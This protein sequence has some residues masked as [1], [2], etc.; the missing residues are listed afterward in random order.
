MSAERAIVTD[1][2]AHKVEVFRQRKNQRNLVTKL[3]LPDDPILQQRK[4]ADKVFDTEYNVTKP[5]KDNSDWKTTDE[6]YERAKSSYDNVI[7]PFQEPPKVYKLEKV[8]PV[9]SGNHDGKYIYLTLF[10]FSIESAWIRLKQTNVLSYY[11]IS[12]FPM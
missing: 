5:A 3:E 6:Y 9:K 2:E 7:A 4:I 10:Y 1:G 12:I 8:T 11:N